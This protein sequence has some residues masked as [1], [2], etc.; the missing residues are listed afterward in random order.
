MHKLRKQCYEPCLCNSL[1]LLLLPTNRKD[2][3]KGDSERLSFYHKKRVN[4]DTILFNPFDMSSGSLFAINLGRYHLI[5]DK[6]N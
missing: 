5:T 2:T 1:H 6:I 3:T 4:V